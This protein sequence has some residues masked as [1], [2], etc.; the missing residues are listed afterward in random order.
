[1]R[2][3]IPSACPSIAPS[4]LTH[5][6][7]G[8]SRLRVLVAIACL[9]AFS[10][11][12]LAAAAT[13]TAT[14]LAIASGGSA[15]TTVPSGTIVSLT[16]TVTAGGAA[17]TPGIVMFCDANVDSCTNS[18]VVGAAQLSSAGT[19]AI[20]FAPPVGSHNYQA[21]FIGTATGSLLASS[22]SAA[23]TLTVSGSTQTAISSSGSTGNYTLTGTVTAP[24]MVLPTGSV[25]FADTGN[26]FPLGTQSLGAATGA[27]NFGSES[28]PSISN[29]NPYFTVV[30]DFNNDGKMDIALAPGTITAGGEV[31]W[32]NVTVLLGN[33]DGTFTVGS[34]IPV[35]P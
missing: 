14:T 24:A 12:L 11:S 8:F 32:G 10:G 29:G 16:A 35:N 2:V 4:C 17:V 25:S 26:Q 13:A 21:V 22:T 27:I 18:G 30:G 6:S 20:R 15:V 33:G 34:T 31:A 5:R 3:A 9:A 7:R 28:D 19:A 23:Q 1:M